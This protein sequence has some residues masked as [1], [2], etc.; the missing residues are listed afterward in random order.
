MRRQRQT[1]EGVCDAITTGGHGGG[2]SASDHP[3]KPKTLT[4]IVGALRE[5]GLSRADELRRHIEDLP[6]Q[7]DRPYLSAGPGHL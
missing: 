6:P 5:Q 7:D 1:R 4:A 2:P 3:T